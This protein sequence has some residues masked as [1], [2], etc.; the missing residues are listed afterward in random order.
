MINSIN[1]YLPTSDDPSFQLA[2]N[3]D[4]LLQFQRYNDCASRLLSI[5]LYPLEHLYNYNV[6]GSPTCAAH[7]GFSSLGVPRRHMP[8]VVLLYYRENH[9]TPHMQPALSFTTLSKF[10]TIHSIAPLYVEMK[11]HSHCILSNHQIR[12]SSSFIQS[13]LLYSMV[14]IHSTNS[15]SLP[16]PRNHFSLS[17]DNSI[18]V[19]A[20]SGRTVP[21]K[22]NSPYTN[23]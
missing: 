20:N 5:P 8:T 3:H 4:E 7:Q 11:W 16:Q 22:Q 13:P 12:T 21:A 2:I 9:R 14:V 1:P 18:P 10:V 19:R 17:V 15:E 6:C 23:G